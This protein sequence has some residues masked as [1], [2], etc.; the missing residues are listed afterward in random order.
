[1]SQ[2][3]ELPF[4]A[5]QFYATASYRCSYLPDQMARS[6]VAAPGHLIHAETYSDL[7]QQGFRRSGLFTYRPHCDHCRACVPVRIDAAAFAANRSQR[8]A[9]KAHNDLRAHVATLGWS[10]EH[11]ALYSR[12]QTARHP[13][14]G[15]DED[16]RTQYSQ[17]LLASRVNS[18][19]VEFR[20]AQGILQMVSILDI[21]NDGLSSVYTFYDPDV[22][23]SLGTYG[24]LWQIKECQKM[25]LPFLYLGY[26]IK[27][28]PKMNYKSNFKPAQ[29]LID[30]R[31]QPL[32]D[33]QHESAI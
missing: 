18:R 17:F 13:G 29:Y 14:G 27:E 16:S 24:V 4:S 19:L 31:W 33:H 11:Y 6:Q 1:M 10:N 20:N 22:A 7:V 25:G 3:Q 15:M 21:L 26:W 9:A 5:I 28:S 8:R 23:G 30:G 12:Y 32:S 2:I